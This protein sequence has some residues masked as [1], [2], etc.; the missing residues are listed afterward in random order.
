MK[1]PSS[2]G[3]LLQYLSAQLTFRIHQLS[4]YIVFYILDIAGKDLKR[5]YPH[6]MRD[7]LLFIRDPKDGFIKRVN[8]YF[9]SGAVNNEPQ[10]HKDVLNSSSDLKS[11]L[12]ESREFVAKLKSVSEAL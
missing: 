4:A 8:T 9:D 10:N 12:K 7:I 1:H 11:E 3:G 6:P 2:L 5:A